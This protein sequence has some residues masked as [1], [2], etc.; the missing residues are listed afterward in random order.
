MP[1][2]K[3]LCDYYR[4]FERFDTFA[5]DGS[6][7]G[8]EDYFRFGDHTLFGTC[9]RRNAVRSNNPAQQA[10]KSAANTPSEAI[11]LPFDVVKAIDNLRLERYCTST[12]K[13]PGN[14]LL[15]RAYYFARPLMP[16]R[17]RRH[18]QK[19]RLNKWRQLTFP[20]WPVDRTVDKVIGDL[21]LSS[22][23][24]HGVDRIPFIWFWPEGATSAAMVTHDV[25]T[26]RG[27]DLCSTIMD[28]DDAFGIKGAFSVVP[29]KRYGVMPTYIDSIWGRGFEVVV[30]D[31]NHDGHLYS[32]H[33][34]FVDRAAKINE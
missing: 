7:S 5:R 6:D 11:D 2:N 12:E 33:A 21:L 3:L 19:V 14:S 13:H 32:D 28:I 31:L 29:E 15:G 27:R 30:H 20:R 18:L 17:V 26:A 1:R 24:A 16:L 9:S 4:C 34:T 8:K 23:H 25:E 22:R 10:A